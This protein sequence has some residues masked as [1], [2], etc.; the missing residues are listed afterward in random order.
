M[1]RL[2]WADEEL[3]PSSDMTPLIRASEGLQPSRTTRCSAHTTIPSDSRCAVLAFALGLY[4][5]PCHDNGRADGSLVFR[6]SPE[7]RATP[8]TPPEQ[9]ADLG[10][11]ASR[12][13]FAVT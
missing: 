2:R 8:L 11:P 7:T 10:A 6:S 3:R 9:K 4:D 13:A 12:V 5:S 1:K